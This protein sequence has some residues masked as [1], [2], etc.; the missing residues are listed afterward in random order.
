MKKIYGPLKKFIL[1]LLSLVCLYIVAAPTLLRFSDTYK[2]AS[3][4]TPYGWQDEGYVLG[5]ALQVYKEGYL[6]FRC[7]ENSPSQ[8]YG[9]TQVFLDA[10]TLKLFPD[11][12]LQK[13]AYRETPTS[14]WFFMSDYPEALRI[15][16]LTRVFY[17]ALL[18]VFLFL[19]A[20]KAKFPWLMSLALGFGIASFNI[21]YV[22]WQGLKNEY[23]SVIWMLLFQLSAFYSLFEPNVRLSKPVSKRFLFALFIGVLS[24]GVKFSNI[25]PV[26]FFVPAYFIVTRLKGVSWKNL[27]T[28]IVTGAIFTALLWAVFNPNIRIS[29]TESAFFLGMLQVGKKEFDWTNTV[30]EFYSVGFI[31]LW[32]LYFM[33]LTWL[34]TF[35]R[36][37]WTHEFLPWGYFIFVPT[38]WTV[39]TLKSAWMRHAYY[40]PPVVWGLGAAFLMLSRRRVILAPLFKLIFVGCMLYSVINAPGWAPGLAANWPKEVTKKMKAVTW[41]RERHGIDAVLNDPSA[42]DYHWAIDLA[43][44]PAMSKEVIPTESILYF[45]SLSESPSQVSKAIGERWPQEHVKKT[46]KILATCWGKIHSEPLLY[47]PAAEAWSQALA[48]SC[49]QWAPDETELSL[50]RAYPFENGIKPEAF[51]VVDDLLL[52]TQSHSQPEILELHKNQINPRVL[53]GAIQGVDYWFSP[54]V[55]YQPTVLLGEFRWEHGFQSVDFEVESNCK[56]QGTLTVE[57]HTENQNVSQNF[58]LDVSTQTCT[59]YPLICRLGLEK[60]WTKR[61]PLKIHL[62]SSLSGLPLVAAHTRATLKISA[63]GLEKARCRAALQLIEF[64]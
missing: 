1:F 33:A 42:R 45:D 28:Q 24:I 52:L 5:P 47:N 41:D 3:V 48:V 36:R 2:S 29:S 40:L 7:R 12:W 11:S 46:I 10:F 37:D 25:M 61:Y 63:E 20:R 15:L 53:R 60:W 4:K 17:A 26:V 22:S 43:L 57:M 8:C 18:C 58:S 39:L 34:A 19:L 14:R 56:K 32:P 62:E 50:R 54:L 27:I 64:K 35:K 59:D 23:P 21:F 9:S 51:T 44:R 6:G 13:G 16:R 55:L 38:F 49:T 31:S 30:Q